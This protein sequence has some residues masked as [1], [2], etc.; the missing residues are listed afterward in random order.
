MLFRYA[1]LPI[2]QLTEEAQEAKNKEYRRFREFN[3]RKCDRLSTTE[4]LMHMLL[5]SSDPLL[6]SARVKTKKKLKKL[7]PEAKDLLLIEK[8]CDEEDVECVEKKEGCNDSSNSDSYS[9]SDSD[10]E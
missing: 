7:W 1:I 5:V 2:G 3:T 9:D 10:S 6:S 4:D 8:G